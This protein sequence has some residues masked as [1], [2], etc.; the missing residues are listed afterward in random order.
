MSTTEPRAT[1]RMT[2]NAPGGNAVLLAIL[3]VCGTPTIVLLAVPFSAV[4]AIWYL[5]PA[6]LQP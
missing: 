3:V 5:L 1:S 6:R 2:R 4:G